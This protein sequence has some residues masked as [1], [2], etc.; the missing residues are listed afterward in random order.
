MTVDLHAPIDDTKVKT[1]KKS[2]KSKPAPAEDVSEVSEAVP[3]QGDAPIGGLYVTLRAA[4]P[5]VMSVMCPFHQMM[6]QRYLPRKRRRSTRSTRRISPR[7][8]IL[9]RI[10]R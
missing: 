2:K 6:P 4:H 10:H 1:K 5:G 3:A 7:N 9:E 8:T